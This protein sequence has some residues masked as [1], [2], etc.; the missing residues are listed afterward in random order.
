MKRLRLPSRPRSLS[1]ES[2]L[3]RQLGHRLPP[4]PSRRRHCRP[5]FRR[6]RRP[7]RTHP[8]QVHL[9]YP[10]SGRHRPPPAS[11]QL[12]R[13]QHTRRP[14]S[15]LK[16]RSM[17]AR[18]CPTLRDG[19]HSHSS[20]SAPVGATEEATRVVFLSQATPAI[21]PLRSRLRLRIRRCRARTRHSRR[22][23]TTPHRLPLPKGRKT[24]PR[25]A[26]VRVTTRVR[27]R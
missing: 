19:R 14:L 20:R 9:R 5:R 18:A 25:T 12:T 16:A 13:R 7:R 8:R 2:P 17:P 15:W 11:H 27:R 21:G 4:Q 10:R 23:T 22:N 6:A 3:N 1:L 26:P 24:S